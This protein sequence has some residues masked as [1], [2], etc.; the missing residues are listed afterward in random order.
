MLH[1]PASFYPDEE[2]PPC[3]YWLG[4]A[5]KTK[6]GGLGDVGIMVTDE[7][8]DEYI[9]TQPHSIA[10]AWVVPEETGADKQ[11]ANN[12]AAAADDLMDVVI[13]DGFTITAS[14]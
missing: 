1:I 11:G 4:K 10:A 13:L 9:I 2:A 12:G 7:D 3:G 14:Q 6:K 8:G 5:V